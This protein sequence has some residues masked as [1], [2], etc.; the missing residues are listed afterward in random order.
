[1][2]SQHNCDFELNRKKVINQFTL[3]FYRPI[4]K[5]TGNVVQDAYNAFADAD[6]DHDGEL[7]RDEFAIWYG[8][9]FTAEYKG[10]ATSTSITAGDGFIAGFWNSIAMII[11]T[12]LGDK[13]FFVAAISKL[14]Q[15]L[16]TMKMR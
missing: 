12:E 6:T 3:I 14:L 7:E 4:S 9:K 11:V 1:M 16:C 10:G 2:K 13:T 8:S 15:M 5:E